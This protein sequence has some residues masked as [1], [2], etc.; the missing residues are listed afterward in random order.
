MRTAM[1]KPYRIP[2]KIK[3]QIKKIVDKNHIYQSMAYSFGIPTDFLFLDG[4]TLGKIGERIT[5]Q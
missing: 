4:K 2:R 5:F 1:N 3:K